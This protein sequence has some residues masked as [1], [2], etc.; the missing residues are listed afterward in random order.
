M[1]LKI[2]T[3]SQSWL[4][5]KQALHS[6]G[7]KFIVQDDLFDPYKTLFIDKRHEDPEGGKL[8]HGFIVYNGGAIIDSQ[9]QEV[10]EQE[11][12][13]PVE[14]QDKP[15]AKSTTSV[16]AASTACASCGCRIGPGQRNTK[17]C[18]CVCH[19]TDRP[20]A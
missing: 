6:A 3:D 4:Y 12:T 11:I 5:L 7:L 13:T 15:A 20:A 19:G 14:I 17:G 1:I 9:V 10:Y 8:S 16:A 2:S 18:Q